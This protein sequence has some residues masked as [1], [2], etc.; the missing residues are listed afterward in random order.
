[1]LYLPHGLC[2][3]YFTLPLEDTWLQT[4]RRHTGLSLKLSPWWLSW[5]WGGGQL[6]A[7]EFRCAW[8]QYSLGLATDILK[9]ASKQAIWKKLACLQSGIHV[10]VSILLSKSPTTLDTYTGQGLFRSV[11]ELY[12]HAI[13]AVTPCKTLPTPGVQRQL[14][15]ARWFPW[16][17]QDKLWLLL[18]LVSLCSLKLL[19]HL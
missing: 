11:H 6:F 9:A 8:L 2:G 1:M 15:K 7:S 18:C 12:R 10:L 19:C 14:R 17:Y 3:T 5:D 16:G 13:D 4:T